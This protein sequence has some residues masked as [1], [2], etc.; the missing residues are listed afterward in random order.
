VQL[1]RVGGKDLLH[2]LLNPARLPRPLRHPEGRLGFGLLVRERGAGL[3]VRVVPLVQVGLLVQ[4]MPL[5]QVGLLVQ[6]VPLV[7]VGLL[8]QVGLLAQVG[9]LV[10][11]CL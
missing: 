3:L 7:Q 9:L 10:Q 4:V 2:L 11:L 8:L 1:Q 5:V 6:V